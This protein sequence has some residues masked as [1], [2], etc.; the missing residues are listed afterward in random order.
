MRGVRASAPG[1]PHRNRLH[2]ADVPLCDIRRTPAP[3]GPERYP[4]A[5]V[6]PSTWPTVCWSKCAEINSA[7]CSFE[8]QE[9]PHTARSRHGLNG[10]LSHEHLG[11]S[12]A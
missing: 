10:T 4:V 1:A 2:R 9:S 5:K 11:L 6:A 3:E 7:H 8:G 12:F